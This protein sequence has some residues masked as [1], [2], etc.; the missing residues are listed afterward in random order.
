VKSKTRC[1]QLQ[2]YKGN[3]AT[4]EIMRTLIKNQRTYKHRIGSM[5]NEQN[6]VKNEEVDYDGNDDRNSDMESMYVED[7][8]GLD[9]DEDDNGED[10]NGEDDNGEDDNGEDGRDKGDNGMEIHRGNDEDGNGTEINSGDDG[11][12][13]NGT[14]ISSSGDGG[15]DKER[16][17]GKAINGSRGLPGGKDSGESTKRKLKVTQDDEQGAKAKRTKRDGSGGGSGGHPIDEES[18]AEEE[19]WQK[20]VIGTVTFSFC[21]SRFLILKRLEI[22]LLYFENYIL[23]IHYQAMFFCYLNT[24]KFR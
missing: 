14:K 6:M 7:K 10:D 20:K 21:K 12:D 15:E 24:P 11:G 3:W 2:R 9:S 5:D 13:G 4:L 19:S 8:K 17:H 22:P 18:N 1:K 16:T 23:Y